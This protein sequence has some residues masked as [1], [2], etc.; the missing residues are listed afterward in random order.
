MNYM[1]S[2]YDDFGVYPAQ[3]AN[4]LRLENAER[5]MQRFFVGKA[6]ISD[7]EHEALIRS[8]NPG[9]QFYENL[10]QA[11]LM[12]E[13][14]FGPELTVPSML[15][16]TAFRDYAQTDLG[17]VAISRL[18]AWDDEFI[19]RGWRELDGGL[20]E[21]GI[22][23]YAQGKWRPFRVA[24]SG[25]EADTVTQSGLMLVPD[26]LVRDTY[27]TGDIEDPFALIHHELKAH[28]LPLKEAAGLKPGKKMELICVRLESEM[29]NELGLPERTLNWGKDD[30]SLDHTLCERDEH[31]YL[32]LVRQ[33]DGE[34]L[35]M[36]PETERVIGPARFKC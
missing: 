36:N 28:V 12:A 26:K 35:E 15:V 16:E 5:A 6:Q 13:G 33:I 30:G 18:L 2:A 34:L 32:G 19:S 21:A 24:S 4:S 7:L 31:Y 3:I 9:A 17:A 22:E 25:Y 1:L 20:S 23:A 8:I 29:L 14:G 10:H 27:S 11:E